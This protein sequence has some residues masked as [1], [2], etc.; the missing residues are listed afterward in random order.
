MVLSAQHK[1]PSYKKRNSV[2]FIATDREYIDNYSMKETIK[3]P[4]PTKYHAVDVKR[5]AKKM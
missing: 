5:Q 3:T 1:I 2:C 4:G